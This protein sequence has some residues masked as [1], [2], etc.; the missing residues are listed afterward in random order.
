[1]EVDYICGERVRRL[2]GVAR[3]EQE[4]N[5]RITGVQF[6]R[7]DY[8]PLWRKFAPEPDRVSARD[9]KEGRVQPPHPLTLKMAGLVRSTLQELDG[10]RYQHRVQGNIKKDNIKHLTSQELGYL[11]HHIPPEKTIINCHDLIPWVYDQDRS[12]RWRSNLMGMKRAGKI[13]TVSQF[14]KEEITSHLD[15]PEEDIQVIPDAVDHAHFHP[16]VKPRNRTRWGGVESDRYLLYVGS[17]TPRMNLE[18]LLEALAKLKNL[19]PGI[20]LLKI[21]EAQSYGAREILLKKV[22]DLELEKDVIF[23]GYVAEEDLPGFYRTAEVLVYPCLYAGFGLPP[24]EAMAS[25]T[26]VVTSNTTSLPEVVGDAGLMFNPQGVD[27]LVTKLYEV[28][29]Y[30]DLRDKIVKRGLER[31]RI[32]SWEESAEKTLKLYK[33]LEQS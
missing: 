1:M 14:S 13:I 15:Y 28:L 2:Y 23:L 33:L 20:K 4:I 10:Y 29:T 31:A 3:Y 32:F 30:Q 6:N 19:I 9:K 17:E 26:P 25:G 16:Q 21:G 5:K 24:L 11:L 8:Q 7:I 27:E 18:V 22:K 12:Q